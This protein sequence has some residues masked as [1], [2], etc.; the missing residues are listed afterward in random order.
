MENKLKQYFWF[1]FAFVIVFGLEVIKQDHYALC[2]LTGMVLA[3]LWH[4]RAK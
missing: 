2:F 3:D 1:V 4:R